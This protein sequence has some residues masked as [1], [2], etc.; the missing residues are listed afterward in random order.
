[1]IPDFVLQGF[2][3]RRAGLGTG[4]MISDFVLQGFDGRRPGLGT[5]S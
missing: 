1:M 5:G 4:E 2:D 3:G